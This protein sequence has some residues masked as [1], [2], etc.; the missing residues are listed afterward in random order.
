MSRRSARK[1]AFFLLFQMDFNQAEEYEQ[2][3][4]IFFAEAEEPVEEED[5]D[6]IVNEVEGTRAHMEE[7]DQIIGECAKGWNTDRMSKVDLAILRLAVYELR[8]SKD[9]PVGV[10]INEAVEL[11][12]KFSSDEAP[13]FINGILGK[14]VQ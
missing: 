10:A 5:K 8:F 3:K 2:V 1:N 12:K 4:E 9:T 13:G 11:A 7:I 6:F 14:V